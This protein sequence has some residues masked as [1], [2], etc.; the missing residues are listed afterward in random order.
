[1]IYYPLLAKGET[2][3]IS[4]PSSGAPE[5]LHYVVRESTLRMNKRGFQ[6]VIG[7]TVWSQNK[8]ASAPAKLRAK[9]FNSM[10]KE[11]SIDHLIPI[12]GGELLI[13]MLEYTDFKKLDKKW[14]LGYSDTSVL[15]L[16][17][18]LK[19][20]LAT[21]H[22]PN[23][24][25]VRGEQMDETTAKWMEVLATK[26]GDSIVQKASSK[27]QKEWDHANPTSCI[28]HLTENTEWKTISGEEESFNGRLLGGCLDVIRHLVGTPYGDV[29]GFREQFTLGEPV[30]WYFE[31]DQ[32]NTTELRRIL[33]QMKLAGWFNECAG[34]M[35]GRSAANGPVDNYEVKDVYLALAEELGIP[36]VYDIDCG[37]QPPQMTFINGAVAEVTAGK[38]TGKVKQSFK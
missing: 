19:T 32:M 25:D 17:I 23:F 26:E 12:W 22:G 34:I 37:H 21:A 30:V 8:A 6:T 29:A 33:V 31:N 2:I 20:G 38:G 24:V 3:G 16:A 7:E 9:E 14:I 35:F 4:A 5:A 36:I 15:L 10:M 1:M 18:T 28:F 27:Y 11:Q 13:E